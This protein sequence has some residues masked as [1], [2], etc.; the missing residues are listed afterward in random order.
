MKVQSYTFIVLFLLS[1]QFAFAQ[2]RTDSV[3][4]G[5]SVGTSI[6]DISKESVSDNIVTG[7]DNKDVAFKLIGGHQFNDYL[8]IEF[9]YLNLGG[10]YFSDTY[11]DDKYTTSSS[12][13]VDIN[14]L[15]ADLVLSYSLTN[16]VDVFAKLGIFDWSSGEI[17]RVSVTPIEDT[18]EE[19][20]VDFTSRNMDGNDLFY[21]VGLSYQWLNT[22]WIIEYELFNTSVK[23]VDLIS[24]GA[25]FYF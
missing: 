13:N 4:V 3:F 24:V 15:M 18:G 21:G 22:K 2:N 5:F 23:N 8:S 7:F 17:N 12:T 14:G 11:S 25:Q 16:K 19:E 6:F 10:Y 9:G 1:S 20:L